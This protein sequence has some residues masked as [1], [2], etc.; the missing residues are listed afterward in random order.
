V[1]RGWRGTEEDDADRGVVDRDLLPV[2]DVLA[3]V[4][5]TNGT[6]FGV[7]HNHPT[8]RVEPSEP[9][10]RATARLVAGAEAVGFR[11]LDHVVVAD[12]EWRRV[13]VTSS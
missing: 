11:F 12:R 10:R 7:V 5:A 9:D 2:R 3:L 6:A 1:R 8:G 13:E 4:L